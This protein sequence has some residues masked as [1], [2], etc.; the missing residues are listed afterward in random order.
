MTPALVSEIYNL[1]AV[2]VIGFGAIAAV[3]VFGMKR[4]GPMEED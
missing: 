1:V 3:I 2:G 4:L